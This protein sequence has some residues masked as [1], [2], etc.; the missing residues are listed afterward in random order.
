MSGFFAYIIPTMLRMGV[1]IGFTALGGVVSERSGVNNIGL[2]GIMIASSFAA[3]V[4]S[5]YT[6]NAWVGVLFAMMVGVL[7]SAIHSVL[8]ITMGARQGVSSMGLILLAEGACGV[9]I[10]GIFKRV[11]STPQVPNLP[12]TQFLAPIPV[13]GTFLSNLSPFVYISL[14]CLALV[15][16]MFVRT[17]FGLRLTAVGENPLMAQTA[18]IN[19]HRIRYISVLLSGVFGGLGGAMLSIGQMNLYQEG[20]IAGRGYLALGAV[21][22]GRWHPILA[23]LSSLLFGFFDALQLYWQ[24]IPN[25]PVPPEFIQML[26]YLS[27]LVIL[28][29]SSKNLKYFGVSSG[30]KPFTKYVSDGGN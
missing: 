6:G 16:F 30:G 12:K 19:V 20:M 7:I 5:Y 28:A 18:G 1:P 25:N 13:I 17:R 26:P 14:V 4:G 11:G 9:A 8:T 3:V 27:I 21:S 15:Q 24:T 29:I 22:M 23:Y 2:E 10:Q